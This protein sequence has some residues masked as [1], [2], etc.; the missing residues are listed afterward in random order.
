MWARLQ[1]WWHEIPAQGAIERQRVMVFQTLLSAMLATILAAMWLNVVVFG[2]AALTLRGLA[3]NALVL[4]CV[5]GAWTAL[6]RGRFK[7]SVGMVIGAILLGQ[8][9]ALLT[10][11]LRAGGGTLLISAIPIALAGLLIG[12]RSLVLT[13]SACVATVA[14][15]AVLEQAGWLSVGVASPSD[16]GDQATVVVFTVVVSLLGFLLDR[17]GITLREA[18]AKSERAQRDAEQAEAALHASEAHYRSLAEAAHDMIFII[19][20]EGRV[21]YINR[22][23]ARALG[24]QAEEVISQPTAAIFPPQTLEH[25][26]RN[27]RQV[28]ETLQPLYVEAET[29]FSDHELWL[30]TWLAPLLDEAGAARAVLGISRD[31]TERKRAEAAL[32][33]SEERFRQLAENIQDVIW[34]REAASARILYVNPAYETVWGRSRESLYRGETS[35]IETIHPEDREHV[36]RLQQRLSEAEF[37]I[38]EYRIFRADGTPRWI[39][40]QAFAVRDSAGVVSRVAGIA[41]DITER[42]QAEAALLEGQTRLKLLNSIAI[43]ITSGMSAE[44]IIERALRRISQSFPAVRVSYATLDER[45]E[46]QVLKAFGPPDMPPLVS[47]K[48][49]LSHALEYLKILR[50]G[51]VIIAEDVRHDSRL[52]PLSALLAASETQAMLVAPLSH[53]EHLLGLLEFAAPQPRDWTEYELTTLTELADYLSIALRNAQEQQARQEAE[54]ATRAAVERLQIELWERERAEA[55]LREAEARYRTLVEEAPAITYIISVDAGAKISYYVSPQIETVLGFSPEAWVSDPYLWDKQLHPEDREWVIAAAQHARAT[56][57][58]FS[59]EYRIFT[60]D[61]RVV[62]FHDEARWVRDEAGRPRFMQGIEFDITERKRAEEAY[63][64]VV[65]HSLQ[66]LVI[67]QDRRIVFTNPA[68]AR[69]LGYTVEELTALSPPD[70]WALIHPEDQSLLFGRMQAGEAVSPSYEIRALRKDGAV[71]WLRGSANPI[72]YVGRPAMQAAFIDITERKQTEALLAHQLQESQTLAR[73]SQ[74]LAGSLDLP[75]VLH[76]IAEA[77]VALITPA[78]R[79]VIHLLDQVE[80]ILEPVAVAGPDS[81]TLHQRMNF[82]W[83]RGVAGLVI[84]G[85][86]TINLPD[87]QTDPRYMSQEGRGGHV[88]SL[89]VALVYAGEKRLGTLSVYSVA[90]GVFTADDERLLTTLGAQAGLAI[91]NA[92]LFESERRRAEEAEALQQVTQTLISRLNLDELLQTVVEAIAT[93]ASYQYVS[94]FLLQEEGLVLRARKGYALSDGGTLRLDQGIT[95]RVARTAQ[96]TLV[97]DVTQDKDFLPLDALPNVQSAVGVPLLHADELLGVLLVESTASRRLDQNDLHWLVNV[98]RQLSPVIENARL[99]ADLAHALQDEKA[100]RARLVQTEKLAA[101]GRLVASVA[102]ELNNPLQ[103]IQNALYLVKQESSLSAQAREDLQVALSEADRM[104][105]L[106]HRLRETYRPAASEEFKDVSLN[107]LVEEVEKLIAVH[108][109]QSR[110]AWAFDADLTLPSVLGLRDQLKQ[111]VLNLCLNAVE[112]MPQGGA[113]TVRTDRAPETGG[114]WLT[115]ADIGPGIEADAL[116]NIFDPF[117]T[118]KSTGTG[119][120]LAITHDIIRRHNGHIEVESVVGR[121]TAFRVWLPAQSI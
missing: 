29:S 58:P 23:A 121:G 96:P 75:T 109:R 50:R 85:G 72:E 64:A 56:G 93:M 3:P 57:E 115:V 111:A 77:A 90:V 21:E 66:G 19:S 87:A 98:G 76:Q 63:R 88:R 48:A 107:V 43:G 2:S 11:G 97:S 112:A 49:D 26:T 100:T 68:F 60:R 105:G 22:F 65:E 12:R 10:T 53:S 91:Q 52:T 83:G 7:V 106:I 31:I 99:Y 73:I 13:I 9:Q 41:E 74:M 55:D 42:K 101:M 110:V 38:V 1:R 15:V 8:L 45:D 120:G 103:T 24:R 102:H 40:D 116:P 33:E 34:I 18:L 32:R 16:S 39:R 84:A 118:T 59:A 67:F 80:T 82:Q 71:R 54:M 70:V 79:A 6:R 108:L 95:G 28:I 104:A 14:S 92:Q 61:G 37:E 46:L 44:Q 30:G 17:F 94:V 81:G 35:F 119:L 5:V 114:V 20:R 4:L 36:M 25:Q 113:L 117:F 89:L 47:V 69:T 86:Q 27:L 78:E 51:E 62:W